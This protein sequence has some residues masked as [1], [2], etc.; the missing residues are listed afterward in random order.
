MNTLITVVCVL[1]IG[2]LY[3]AHLLGDGIRDD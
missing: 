3:V 1:M 2:S